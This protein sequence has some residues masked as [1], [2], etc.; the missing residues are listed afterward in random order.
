VRQAVV[1]AGGLATRMLPLTEG[2][3]KV[4]LGVA[5]RPFLA[6][7]LKRLELS[8]FSDVLLL[9]GHLGDAVD[10]YLAANPP[11]IGV[12]TLRDGDALLGTAGALKRAEERL[13][14]TFVVTYGDSYL[15]F[16]YAAPLA[17]L[18]SDVSALGCM[19]VFRNA[20]RFEPS[21]AR[22]ADGRVT[23]YDK[24]RPKGESFDC[25]DSGATALRKEVVRGLPP[26]VALDLALILQELAAKGELLAYV[27]RERFYEIG[28][29][30]GLAALEAHLKGSQA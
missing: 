27:A 6:H 4:L 12:A 14:E 8:G 28:S 17:M 29:P 30:A 13:A 1:L 21:N 26:D 16:D 19:A 25:I 15:P 5:G 9:T 23:A 11:A 3:P 20:D 10:S 18:E 2:T 7:L 22:V 24:S